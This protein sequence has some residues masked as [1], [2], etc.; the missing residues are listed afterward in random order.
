MC[1]RA[2]RASRPVSGTGAGASGPLETPARSFAMDR[3]EEERRRHM[4]HWAMFMIMHMEGRDSITPK[5]DVTSALLRLRELI[6]HELEGLAPPVEE[7]RKLGV[8]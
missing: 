7:R 5:Y 3:N 2:T 1:H 6:D 4:C 8:G